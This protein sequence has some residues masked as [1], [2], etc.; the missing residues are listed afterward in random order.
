MY[1]V[2]SIVMQ[3]FVMQSLFVKK[4]LLPSKKEVLFNITPLLV[5]SSKNVLLPFQINELH[6]FWA[7]L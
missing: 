6:L 2:F 1:P 4:G 7:F 3:S 5:V